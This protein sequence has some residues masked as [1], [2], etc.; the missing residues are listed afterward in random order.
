MKRYGHK[1]HVGKRV[2]RFRQWSRKAYAAFASLHVQVSIGFLKEG[3]VA[4]LFRKTRCL[5]SCLVDGTLDGNSTEYRSDGEYRGVFAR[6][7]D[8]I[9]LLFIGGKW[10]IFPTLEKVQ[11]DSRFYILSPRGFIL[12]QGR[13]LSWRSV[14]GFFLHADTREPVSAFFIVQ[15][16]GCK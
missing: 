1:W 15:G 2:F 12:S 13:N 8:W 9:Y 5:S 14:C 11:R 3:V 7:L 16:Y 6:S 4:G 10:Y